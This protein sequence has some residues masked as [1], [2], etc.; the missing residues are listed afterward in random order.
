MLKNLTIRVK[1]LSGFIIVALL[2]GLVGFIGITNIRNIDNA[3]TELYE[4]AT[5]P[6]GYLYDIGTYFQRVRLNTRE[7]L[8]AID[9]IERKK[10][11]D[12]INE[13][14][15]IIKKAND[16]YEATLTDDDEKKHL[17]NTKLL[18]ILIIKV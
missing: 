10:F 9:D 17:Q 1:L 11:I 3:D 18:L 6:L 15:E 8:I 2:S 7:V 14:K 4:K 16:N 5:V 13:L 12:R